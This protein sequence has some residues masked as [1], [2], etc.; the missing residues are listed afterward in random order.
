[1]G[2]AG[3]KAMRGLL[4][5][6]LLGGAVL[7][8]VW[9]LP[10][11]AA[12]P[13]PHAAP[14]PV[15]IGLAAQAD[16]PVIL[17]G[18]GT[19]QAGNTITIESRVD[20][21]VMTADFAE[22][23]LVH[24]GDIL[25][26]IDPR[27]YQAALDAAT[28]AQ[29]RDAAPLVLARLDLARYLALQ[30]S[31]YQTQQGLDQ[32]NAQVAGLQAALA[33]DQAAVATA[34]L[35]LGFTTIRAPIDGRVGER[36]VDAGNMVHA[37]AS[38][39]LTTLVSVQPM[40]ARFT[41]P[42]KY[43]ETIVRQQVAAPLVT[44]LYSEDDQAELASGTLAV[45]DNQVDQA[46]GTIHLK[47]IFGNEDGVLWPGA[48]ISAHLLVNVLHGATTLPTRAVLP[49]LQ[50]DF[51]YVV[52]ARGRTQHRWVKDFDAGNGIA[53]I[54]DGLKPGERVVIDGQYRVTD[55]TLVTETTT[56]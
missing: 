10:H 39:P 48:S 41:L 6:A 46:T 15:V 26:Q 3:S 28:A 17:R 42:E 29:A 5:F 27:P 35:N 37:A 36:L 20:G 25:F 38:L 13:V 23:Q 16:V 21:E 55:G 24:K 31:G 56:Q 30:K 54:E 51:V 2:F 12:A 9:L 44:Q 45:V 50:G 19:I 40:Y 32:Q 34:A 22:G 11:G 33:M 18:I 49:G 8:G 52:D 47:A 43:L 4:A 7:G 14:V 53:V 1:M